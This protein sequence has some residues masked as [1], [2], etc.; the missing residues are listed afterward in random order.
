MK[1]PIFQ[2]AASALVT[3]FTA[4]GSKINFD[5]FK[6]LIEE[7]IAGSIDA[8]VICGTT[9]ESATMSDEEKL[10]AIEFAVKIANKRIPIIAGTGSNNTAHS[11]HLSQEAEKLGVDGLLIVT[12]YY[13]KATQRGLIE[14][15]KA[16]ASST[17][18]PIIM[19]NVPGR[20]GVNMS[21]EAC[22][23]LSSIP[24][25]NAMK[26]A[27]GDVVKS[28]AIKSLC[29]DNLLVYSGDDALTLPILSV[30]GIGV[31]SVISNIAPKNMHDLCQA[32]FDGNIEKSRKLQLDMLDLV[33]S[34]F[35][36]VS[37][38]PVKTALNLLGKNAG[39]LRLPMYE[40]SESNLERL[41]KSMKSYGCF[42]KS[43]A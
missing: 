10:S 24:N 23:E 34:L 12:P 16:I 33:D 19:Y 28:A 9:G 2:G 17:K 30:G 32:F 8:L 13:N 14:H 37:P 27:S 6:S 38:A 40:M 1:T 3:P 31:I 21:A 4:D 7:Q 43:L 11:I 20:T 15:Y 26:E 22:H 5:S 29:G 18:V 25:I 42:E 35:C 36:E 39:A 41:K